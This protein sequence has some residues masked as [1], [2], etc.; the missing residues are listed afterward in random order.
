[1]LLG[2]FGFLPFLWG[3]LKFGTFNPW[4]LAPVAFRG[5]NLRFALRLSPISSW[6]NDRPSAVGIRF[7][8]VERAVY[9]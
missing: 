7:T 5:I 8:A 4:V 6:P 2:S 3:R 1:M 9:W